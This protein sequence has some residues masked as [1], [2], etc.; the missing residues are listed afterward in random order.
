VMLPPRAP[1]GDV[2]A[3]HL[4]VLRLG[5]AAPISRDR[6]IEVLAQN[7][8]GCSVHFIPLHLHPYWRERYALEPDDFP[9]A[10]RTYEKVVSLPLCT[11]MTDQDQERVIAVVREILTA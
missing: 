5:A 11:K 7:G 1:G 10:L 9:H 6:F 2:H 3:W 8:I 4:Y